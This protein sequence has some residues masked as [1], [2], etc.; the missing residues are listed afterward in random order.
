M[1]PNCFSK[2]FNKI[3]LQM[4]KQRNSEFFKVLMRMLDIVV[5]VVGG[6]GGGVGGVGGGG[7]GGGVGGGGGGG[8]NL[9]K[10]FHWQGKGRR[11][12][13]EGAVGR[14]SADVIGVEAATLCSEL[15]DGVAHEYILLMSVDEEQPHT[16]HLGRVGEQHLEAW[17][18]GAVW[19][20]SRQGA[21]CK[22]HGRMYPSTWNVGSGGSWRMVP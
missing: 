18:G 19:Q 11:A 4:M 1:M 7:G 22:H 20:A 16:S 9:S 2:E 21:H 5:V 13:D 8:G 3:G 14:G 15:V 12:E 17:G 6:G 10:L